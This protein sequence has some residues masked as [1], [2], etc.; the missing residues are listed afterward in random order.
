MKAHKVGLFLI[1]ILCLSNCSEISTKNKEV[2]IYSTNTEFENSG[3]FTDSIGFSEIGEIVYKTSEYSRSGNY[4]VKLDSTNRYGFNLKI[5]DPKEGELYQASVWQRK[6]AL[7]GALICAI[8]G[9]NERNVRT[10]KTNS[11][12]EKWFKHSLNLIIGKDVESLNFYVFAGGKVAYFDDIEI[13]RFAKIPSI[14]KE[15][16]SNLLKIYIPKESKLSLDDYTNGALASSVISKKY[17]KYV[18]AFILM[19]NDSIPIEMRL[20]G[21]WTDHLTSGKISYRIKV[22]GNNSF[23]GLKTFSIQHPST[24]NYMH[25]WFMHKLCNKEGLLSTTYKMIP[26]VIN[27]VNKGTYALEEHFDKQLLESRNRREGP[28]VK[29][30]ESGVWAITFLGELRNNKSYPYFRASFNSLFKKNRTLKNTVLK[31]EL[32]E[33]MKLLDLFKNFSE[34]VDDIFDIKKIAKFYALLELG[35]VD[36]AHA[37]H[38]RRFYFNPITQKLELIGY[39]MLP[40]QVN[41]GRLYIYNK[42]ISNKGP[43]EMQLT[44]MTLKS[45]GFKDYYMMY[46]K[47]FSDTAYLNNVFYKMEQ[48]LSHNEML[49]ANEI[50]DYSFDRNFYHQRAKIMRNDF[51]KLDS[52]WQVYLDR[53]PNQT[54]IIEEKYYTPNIDS[55]Y[56]E[57]I[58]INSYV[59]KVDSVNY[60]VEIDNF[61]LNGVNILGYK[62]KGDTVIYFDDPIFMEPFVNRKIESTISF[63]VNKKPKK[64]IFEISNN[65][66]REY[67]KKVLKWEKPKGITSRMELSHSFNLNSSF[68]KIKD[69]VLSFKKGNYQIDQLLYIPSKYSV[70]IEKGTSIDFVKGGGIIANNSFTAIGEINHPINFTSSD[71][72]NHGITIL[73]GD[74]V[75]ISYVNFDSLNSL[76]YKKWNLTGAVS[77][78]ESETRINN[79]KIRNNTCEDGLNIIRSNFMID[80]L[81]VSGTKSDGFDADFC[82][83]EIKNSRFENTGNDCIDFSGSI[84]NISNIVIIN[85]GDKGISGGER[86]TLTINNINI[87]GAITGIAAKD[88]TKITGDNISITNAEFGVAAFQKKAEYDK[89]SID[90]TNVVYTNLQQYGLV[91]L[92]SYVVIE[93]KYYYGG[94]VIDIDKLY[95]RFEK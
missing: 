71:G 6:G 33:A 65:P 13:K 21:D 80:S 38:N 77:I 19:K 7:D 20:K 30:D 16:S 73:Q 3:F 87:D 34:N 79:C 74:L 32:H 15:E 56:I 2:T 90:I 29:M 78:Y 26:V 52:A 40:G 85:S 76:H 62:I 17:K 49:L 43:E 64:I 86:S 4:S 24:R 83:G 67:S 10:W 55:F 58:S 42:I 60:E 51:E 37:W 27:G 66:G 44:K 70:V 12:G 50:Q 53:N 88:D 69:S 5:K 63:I 28:I 35:N 89:A 11:N 22:K 23:A 84:I 14:K 45:T 59:H 75:Q 91:D 93:G 72:N 36:H 9:E 8:K 68:Y 25:E 47:Q 92:G 81:F 54:D 41:T 61:H 82:T 46:I 57:D 48:E 39:D 1:G 94:M 95:A 31:N 18:D